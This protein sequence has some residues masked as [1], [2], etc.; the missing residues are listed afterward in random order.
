MFPDY[1]FG[2]IT[3]EVRPGERQLFLDDGGIASMESLRRTM[4]RLE[5]QGAVLIADQPWERIVLSWS[6]PEWVPES[7]CF[8]LFYLTHTT[9]GETG[10]A[11]AES[12]DGKTWTKPILRLQEIN[13]SFEN[14]L[15]TKDLM[16]NV[17]YDPDD[18]DVSR[19]YKAVGLCDRIFSGLEPVLR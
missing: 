17:I 3:F 18:P 7:R 1:L 8:K 10:I 4:G 6:S 13:G 9:T 14:N 11:Y 19:R 2:W 15:V 12:R 5:K 16:Y